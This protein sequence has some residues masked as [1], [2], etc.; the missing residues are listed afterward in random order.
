MVP[1]YQADALIGSHCTVVPLPLEPDLLDSNLNFDYIDYQP[2]YQSASRLE[3]HDDR[4]VLFN[5][6]ARLPPYPIHFRPAVEPQA[7]LFLWKPQQIENEVERIDL[8]G[9]EAGSGLR[10]DYFLIWGRP[11]RQ[12]P[13][14]RAQVEN[15]LSQFDEIY[16]SNSG[17]VKLYRRRGVHNALCTM[18]TPATHS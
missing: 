1:L 9:Y 10:V 13:A 16:H 8:K 18:D 6:L 2:F 7:N 5:Y 3:L 14:I 4:V 17:V 12:P 11:S 15:V